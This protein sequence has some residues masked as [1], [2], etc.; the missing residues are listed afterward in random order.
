MELLVIIVTLLTALGMFFIW[1]KIDLSKL[2]SFFDRSSYPK[3]IAKRY[4]QYFEALKTVHPDLTEAELSEILE[5]PDT[6]FLKQMSLGTEI[7]PFEQLDDFCCRAIISSEWLKHGKYGL[8]QTI[9]ESEYNPY[10]TIKL[11]DERWPERLGVIRSDNEY[12]EVLLVGQFDDYRWK[13]YPVG[14]HF[15]KNNGSTGARQL[16][17]FYRFVEYLKKDYSH[18]C[19][20]FGK[21]INDDLF[22]KLQKGQ[23][24]PGTHFHFGSGQD[25]WWMDFTNLVREYPEH[26]TEFQEAREIIR[27]YIELD[28][29]FKKFIDEDGHRRTVFG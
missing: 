16:S 4:Q 28:I 12:G 19:S 8:F 2:S 5:Y 15:S 18:N 1:P 10:D 7:I 29:H 6:Q 21:T 26:G 20:V 11:L 25:Y 9:L 24:Y 14:V 23:E 13:I 17:E 27:K 3:R 22:Q